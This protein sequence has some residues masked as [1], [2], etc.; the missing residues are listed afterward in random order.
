M[1]ADKLF[2]PDHIVPAPEFIAAAAEGAG[3]RKAQMCVEVG[4][5]PVQ[6]GVL[7]PG[8]TD[9]GVE[10]EDTHGLQPQGK[11]V[12][13][14]ASQTAFPGVVVQIDGQ[15]ARPVVGGTPHKG[16]GVGIALHR[17]VPLNDQIG[18]PE[19]D[20]AH[21]CGELLQSGDGTLKADGSVLHIIGVDL[22]KTGCICQRC[23]PHGNIIHKNTSLFCSRMVPA[24]IIARRAGNENHVPAVFSGGKAPQKTPALRLGQ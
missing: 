19:H 16:S 20:A 14:L 10:V 5:V 3:K 1:P 12:V 6:V 11:F 7:L 23:V 24:P 4:T 21:P 18:V 8:H 2:H 13:Q 15:L 22:Q 17:V 9:A